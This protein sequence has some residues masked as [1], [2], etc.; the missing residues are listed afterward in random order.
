M[1]LGKTVRVSDRMRS[2]WGIQILDH[3]DGDPYRTAVATTDT[4]WG[5]SRDLRCPQQPN[6][7]WG[8]WSDGHSRCWFFY[9]TNQKD[10]GTV[11]NGCQNSPLW[12]TQHFTFLCVY[13]VQTAVWF[14]PELK[15]EVCVKFVSLIP[16]IKQKSRAQKQRKLHILRTTAGQ[17]AWRRIAQ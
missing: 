12:Q 6:F 5:V 13:I 15:E 3:N 7:H 10:W 1:V 4:S 11:R 9:V 17:Q 16:Q 14:R 8:Q 2:C